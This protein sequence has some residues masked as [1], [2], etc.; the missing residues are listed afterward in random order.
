M[1]AEKLVQVIMDPLRGTTL[2]WRVYWIYG[3][4]IAIVLNLLLLIIPLGTFAV[5]VMLLL[6]LVAA[7][8]WVICLWQC[9]YNC[10]SRQLGHIIRVSVAASVPLIP[11]FAYFIVTGDVA[12][13]H[14]TT[15]WSGP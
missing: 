13:R 7:T 8:Y 3:A 1:A 6:G 10:R 5:R 12:G 4:V 15:R 2:L 11:V 9:A 14:L